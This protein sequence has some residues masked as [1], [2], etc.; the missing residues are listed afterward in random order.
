MF[1]EKFLKPFAKIPQPTE[2]ELEIARKANEEADPTTYS[3]LAPE[4]LVRTIDGAYT[5]GVDTFHKLPEHKHFLNQQIAVRLMKGVVPVAD[6]VAG[7]DGAFYSKDMPH[8]RIE[9]SGTRAE[10]EANRLVL[11]LLLHDG[12]HSLTL[13][14]DAK[15]TVASQN[16]KV[17][18]GAA[19]FYDLELSD[20]E[21]GTNRNLTPE[22]TAQ[23]KAV[24]TEKLMALQSQYEGESGKSLFGAI[25]AGDQAL[26]PSDA[27]DLFMG[28]ID[29]ALAEAA[30][31]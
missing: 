3:Q 2:E 10:A 23:T 13:P 19:T 1:G 15:G 16:M 8:E 14:A 9:Q 20:L 7:N 31:A 5:D 30:R 27:Y 4:S 22:P 29:H 25:V 28:R 6:V 18:Q 26:N 24:L 17:G 12:D 21:S 11:E